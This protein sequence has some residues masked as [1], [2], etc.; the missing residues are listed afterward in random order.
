MKAV[1][2]LLAILTAI[3]VL[4]AQGGPPGGGPGGGSTG[5]GDGIWRRNAAYGEPQTFDTC[6]GHQTNTGAY[7]YHVNPLCLRAQLGDNVVLVKN[8]RVGAVYQEKTSGFTHSPILGWAQDGYPIYGPYGYTDPTNSASPVKRLVSSYQLRSITTRTSLP[9]WSLPNHSGVSQQLTSSQYGPP[10]STGYP[11]G[12]YLEDYDYISGLGDL[13]EYNGRTTVTP[14]FPNGT[15]A[16]FITLDSSG[17]PAFP[18]VLAGQYY[19]TASGE[20]VQSVSG[21]VQ[22]YFQNSTYTQTPVTTPILASWATKNSTKFASIISGLDPA[23]GAVTTWPGTEPSGIST[24]GSVTTPTYAEV[25]QIQYSTSTVYINANG[26]PGYTLGPWFGFQ[27]NGGVFVNFPSSQ[28]LLYQFP[29]SPAPASSLTSTGGGA[30]GLWVNGVEVFNFMDGA[31]Y[32][33]SAGVDEGPGDVT[34]GVVN[35]SA[36]SSEGGPVAPNSILSSYPLFGATIA[37]STAAASSANW[38]TTLGGATVTVKDS[39]ATTRTAQISYASPTQLN[40]VVPSGTAAGVATVTVTVG[41]SSTTGSLNVVASYPNLFIL[42]TAS[43]AAAYVQYQNGQVSSVYQVQNSAIVAQSVSA[44]SAS[45]AAYLVLA[46][47]GLGTASGATSQVVTATIGGVNATVSYAGA[48]GTY[49]GLDQY[50]ILIPSSLAGAGQVAVIVT[51]AGL[52]SNTVYIT[53]Q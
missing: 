10:V 51:A 23:A 53:L 37:S 4:Y 13:D 22:D 31:S 1:S 39:A 36:A 49:P 33:N 44:G 20:Q 43:L 27:T 29:S 18:Y 32:S 25:Q 7:H 48:Q 6:L 14:D 41:S 3:P 5:N 45:N 11:L 34:P 2:T 17:N 47:S 40:F 12:R 50:N 26:L 52:P 30:C 9:T 38:P 16:Y 21:T 19:G 8:S 28:S 24:S 35:V 46:G 15:Y 42:N